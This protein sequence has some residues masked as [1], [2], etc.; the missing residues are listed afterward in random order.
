LAKLFFDYQDYTNLSL[1]E[2]IAI[3][4]YMDANDLTALTLLIQENKEITAHMRRFIVDLVNKKIKR[5][6]G[7]K[8]STFNRDYEIYQQIEVSLDN[9]CTLTS[10][11]EK[12]GVA[13]TIAG[14][15]GVTEETALTAYYYIKNKL[16]ESNRISQE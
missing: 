12:N 10:N 13:A 2:V 7:K 6:A 9:K 4:D 11:R 1:N 5:K 14:K 15:F 3:S 8:P 16:T